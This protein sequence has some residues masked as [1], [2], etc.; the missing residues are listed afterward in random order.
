MRKPY[1]TAVETHEASK[2]RYKLSG[3]QWH[4]RLHAIACVHSRI[5]GAVVVRE[6]R[7]DSRMDWQ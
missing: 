2:L 1:V 5:A 3:T 4:V 7:N 6:D